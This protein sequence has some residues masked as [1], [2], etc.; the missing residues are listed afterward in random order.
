MEARDISER[1]VEKMQQNIERLGVINMQA[2][3]RDAMNYD[4]S[5]FH[6]ADIVLCDL[7]CSGLGVIG[8]KQDIK[9]K[10][11]PTRQEE[12][13]SIQ[14]RILSVSQNYVKPGGTLIYSTCT[15]GADENQVNLKYFLENYPFRL[16]SI[17]SYIPEALR[18]RTTEG[19]YLQ[20]LPGI[21]QT[22]GFFLARFRRLS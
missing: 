19:G 6:K 4:E 22:D 11:N 8:K 15:I 13:V 5:S 2:A 14:R 12:L 16:E 18:G 3:I 7:P 10:M 21:H 20:L 1:K 17:N 9:Y